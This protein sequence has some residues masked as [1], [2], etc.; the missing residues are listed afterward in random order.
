MYKS[1]AL[2]DGSYR[3]SVTSKSSVCIDIDDLFAARPLPKASESFDDWFASAGPDTKPDSYFDSLFAESP[4]PLRPSS[5][6]PASAAAAA[7]PASSMFAPSPKQIDSD[8]ELVKH[9][10]D[11]VGSAI[12]RYNEAARANHSAAV[13]L[14]SRGPASSFSPGSPQQ[15]SSP[16]VVLATVKPATKRRVSKPKEA[17]AVAP[18]PTTPTMAS[19]AGETPDTPVK[20]STAVRKPSASRTKLKSSTDLSRT[21]SELDDA[22]LPVAKKVV[23]ATLTADGE[24]A[25]PMVELS[26]AG[27]EESHDNRSEQ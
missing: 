4:L 23:R 12:E 22:A 14:D 13:G 6:S 1:S 11:S 9:A 20:S 3:P 27:E 26:A 2:V 21:A 16:V 7:V 19:A 18:M 24:I 25:G 15:P 10:R 8:P 5:A 17:A